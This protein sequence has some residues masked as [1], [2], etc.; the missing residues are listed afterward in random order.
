MLRIFPYIAPEKLLSVFNQKN[1]VVLLLSGK[2]NKS[3]IYRDLVYKKPTDSFETHGI[4]LN[5]ED[6]KQNLNASWSILAF[7]P[8]RQYWNTDR[9]FLSSVEKDWKLVQNNLPVKEIEHMHHYH[10]PFI[11]GVI[12]LLSY[13]LSYYLEKLPKLEAALKDW[14]DLALGLYDSAICFDHIHQKCIAFSWG[15]FKQ[16]K[17]IRNHKIMAFFNQVETGINSVLSRQ[18]LDKKTSSQEHRKHV[19]NISKTKDKESVFRKKTARESYIKQLDKTIDY[20]HQ[21]DIFQ[22]NISQEFD[23]ILPKGQAPI[24]VFVKLV[25][26]SPAPFSGYI[27]L[28]EDHIAL[29]NSPERFFLL[30]RDGVIETRPVKGTCRRKQDPKQDYALARNLFISEKDRAENLMIVDLMRNDLSKISISGSVHTTELFAVETYQNVHH[31]VSVIQSRLKEHYT[32]FDILRA[33]FP[34]GSITG[35]PKVR[36][37]EIISEIEQIK[38]HGYCGALG[39]ISFDQRA[40]FNVMI[41]SLSFE[42]IRKHASNSLWKGVIRSGGGIVADSDAKDEYYETE[43]KVSAIKSVLKTI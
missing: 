16:D 27:R 38:R 2:Q 4:H 39:Y 18:V 26:K 17:M 32:G 29:T 6:K 22:A 20:I 43:I 34:A 41:R 5:T 30:D 40:E 33:C 3:R 13:D 15:G 24:D 23:T 25:E 28:N 21:G 36:A 7:D 8:V 19:W 12:G 11:G 1:G 35:A 37:M 10:L 31:L 9:A 14:P 42:R